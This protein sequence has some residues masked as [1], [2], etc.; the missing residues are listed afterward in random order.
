MA[1]KPRRNTKHMAVDGRTHV[2]EFVL[3]TSVTTQLLSEKKAA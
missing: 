1:V 2:S 3:R